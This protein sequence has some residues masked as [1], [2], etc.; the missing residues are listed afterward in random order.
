L[1]SGRIEACISNGTELYDYAAGK[2]IALE[3][4]AKITDLSGQPEINQLND[5][6]VISNGWIHE[7]VIEI[8]RALSKLA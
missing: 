3:A 2:L 7:P 6:F 8:T 4:G 5:V 1:A